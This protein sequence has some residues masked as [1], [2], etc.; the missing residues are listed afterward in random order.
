[1]NNKM[2]HAVMILTG[3]VLIVASFLKVHLMTTQPIVGDHLWEQ[4]E[5]FLIQ[6]PLVLGLGIWLVSGLFRKAGW[7]LGILALLVFLGDTVYK[8]VTGAESCGCFGTVEVDPWVTLFAFNLPFLALM[9][10]FRPKGEKLFDWPRWDHFIGIAVVT[11]LLLPATVGFMAINKVEPVRIDGIQISLPDPVVKDASP[12]LPDPVEIE[13]EVQPGPKAEMPETDQSAPADAQVEPDPGNPEI[14]PEDTKSEPVD[15][16]Q[17]TPEP[18]TANTSTEQENVS[19]KQT[20]AE[21]IQIEQQ[22][23]A[24]EENEN[25]WE[26][27]PLIDIADTLK[28]GMAITVLFHTTC[29]TCRDVIPAY[30][31]AI[32]ELGDIPI[33]VA[34]VEIPPYGDPADSPIPDNAFGIYG[35]LA[36]LGSDEKGRKQK[37]YIGTPL[38]VVTQDGEKVAGWPEGTSPTFDDLLDTVFSQ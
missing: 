1:M 19:E 13:T 34:Y 15:I 37:W 28:E 36:E 10:I 14:S 17:E 25:M 38:V 31:K 22:P 24:S 8:A 32:E 3:S 5:F 11:A 18:Q 30:E 16:S 33:T 26:L 12:A 27:L 20:E 6:V 23:A 35:K 2:N 29:P 9:L 7:I 21:E 4:W